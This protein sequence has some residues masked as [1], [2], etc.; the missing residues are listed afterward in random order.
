[1]KCR[2]GAMML[3][4]LPVAAAAQPA[5]RTRPSRDV[6][7]TY[8]VDGQALSLV[9]GGVQ[10][11]VT[12][13]WDAAGERLRAEVSG[14]S[15]VALVDLRDHSGQAIDTAL[16]VVLPLPIRPQDLQPLTLEGAHLVPAGKDR[17]AGLACNAFTFS[18]SQGPGTV[19]LTP[20]GVPLR[21]QGSVSGKPGS[22]TASSVRYGPI[23][24]DRFTVP[25]GYIALGG[26]GSGGSGPGG[27][28]GLVQKYGGGASLSDLKTLLGHGK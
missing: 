21:G 19:C 1:M 10:G 18:S 28:A 4:L 27:L 8:Q 9:P 24:A 11:P 25:A 12:L 7:V 16:R 22:F 17:V 2:A 13:F 15:Q 26:G 6:V 14:R 5:P 23:P 3:A 20:D